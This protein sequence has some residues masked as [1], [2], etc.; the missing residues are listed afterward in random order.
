MV[1]RVLG[2]Q[3]VSEGCGS[4]CGIVGR[5][6][7]G[8]WTAIAYGKGHPSCLG[9]IFRRRVAYRME[10]DQSAASSAEP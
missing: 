10:K 3:C 6:I 7:G 5:G 9:H 2:L 4:F 1:R 8:H